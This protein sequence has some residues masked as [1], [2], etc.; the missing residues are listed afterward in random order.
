MTKTSQKINREFEDCNGLSSELIDTI[1]HELR[2]PLCIFRNII[3]NALAGTMGKIS[4]KLKE[5][6]LIADAEISRLGRIIRDFMDIAEIEQDKMQLYIKRFTIQSAVNRVIKS[7]RPLA[8]A[9]NIRI[10]ICAPDDPLW[11]EADHNRIVQVLNNLIDNAIK[12]TPDGGQIVVRVNDSDSEIEIE[13]E[14]SGI[15]IPAKEIDNVFTRFVQI[16]KLVGPGRHGTGLGLS[17]TKSLIEIHGGHIWAESAIGS[18]SN[19]R[20]VLPKSQQPPADEIRNGIRCS[21]DAVNN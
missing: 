20:F 9:K 19:F 6:L 18:G 4:P 14:D 15:G 11:L 2:T 17:I 21:S 5:N 3:S 13:V 16:E 8:V 7:L 1:A 10:A 12:F